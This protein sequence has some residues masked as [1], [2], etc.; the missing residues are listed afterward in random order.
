VAGG[1]TYRASNSTVLIKRAGETQLK[2]YD[3]SADV[4]IN[5][6]DLIRLPQRYF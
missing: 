1:Q 5:P 6:G 4:P 3:M 2:S